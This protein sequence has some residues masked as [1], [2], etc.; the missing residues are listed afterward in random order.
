MRQG[1][2]RALL[3]IAAAASLVG[4]AKAAP[5]LSSYLGKYP[6]D[7]VAGISL[8]ANPKFRA[9]VRAAAPSATI[10]QTILTAGV[11]TPVEKQG[12]LLV[13][14]MCEPHN[15]AWHQWTVAMLSPSGPAAIC[16]HDEELMGPEGRWFISGALV[17]RTER[18]WEGNHTDVPNAVF[19]KLA[20]GR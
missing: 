3:A 18:C 8:Y 10:S 2:R 6:S 20:K 9:L 17:A 5:S 13:V 11:E 14:Q 16:Y 19:L 7:K 1:I 15:C 4:A 12:A